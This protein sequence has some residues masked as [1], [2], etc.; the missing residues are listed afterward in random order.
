MIDLYSGATSNGYRATIMLEES[1]L[2]Y[3]L[4]WMDLSTG[5]QKLPD[6]LAINP[7]GMIPALVDA[8][9]PGG[10]P[11]NL[12]QSIAILLYVAEKAGVLLPATGP[13][14]ALVL[15]RLMQAGTDVGTAMTGLM[16]T[17]RFAPEPMPVAAGLFE[18]RFH[19]H[20]GGMD[21][22]LAN[23]EYLAGDY[24]IADIALF[25]LVKRMEA[26]V[27]AAPGLANVKRW[28]AAV[29]ARPAVQRALAKPN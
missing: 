1:G 21:T 2:P 17:T 14:R 28:Y 16:I 12:A 20:L 7:Q 13:E 6:F 29:G 23:A 22:I 25:A 19:T 5:A 10:K 27:Q 26:I 4:H 9:G 11:L 3:R 15:Q 24:S 8:D 18:Q